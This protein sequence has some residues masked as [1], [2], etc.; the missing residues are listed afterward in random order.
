MS[1]LDRTRSFRALC[2]CACAAAAATAAA[3]AGCAAEEPSTLAG[4]PSGTSTGSGTPDAGNAPNKGQEMFA[5]L[6]PDLVAAC[7]TCHEAG[8]I[9]D[10]PFLAAPD[11]YHSVVSWP[12]LVTKDPSQSA[13][14]TYAVSMSGHSGTN[15]DSDAL[16][17]TLRP[18]VVAW[19]EEEAKGIGDAVVE[20]GP[21]I[22]PFV[23]KLGSIN[24]IYLDP[25]GADFVGSAIIFTAS[26]LSDTTLELS[27]LQVFTSADMGVHMV[28]P[29]FV[30]YPKGGEADPDPVDSFSNVD[31]S[32]DVSVVGD[33]GP[34]TLILT[35]WQAEARLSVAFETIEPYSTVQV[36][37]GVEGGAG[38][39]CKDVDAFIANAQG[40]LGT[41]AN[42]HGGSNAQ[43]TS[44]VD[45]SD[46]GADPAA[47]CAQVR[48]RIDP[49]DPAQSQIFVTTDP[50]G[51]ATHPYKF[52]GNQGSFDGFKS[53]LTPWITAE[54]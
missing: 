45:M 36:D 12:G 11:R 8:G 3:A 15:L 40:P 22:E 23:P 24:V 33:L 46:L 5:A 4:T 37:G 34:G 25:L 35:N 32:F 44:A 14:L 9:A 42:C 29:L 10:T 21:S 38:G 26:T 51:S 16:A 31:Q 30:V 49:S 28:H 39:G 47:A 17:D 48:N 27:N 13:F 2:L 7:G 18:K 6:E 52:N 50:G 54:Q 53:A 20:T 41:C 19:L 43:A 1:A